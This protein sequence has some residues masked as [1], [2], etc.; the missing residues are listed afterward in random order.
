MQSITLK[1]ILISSLLL[2]ALSLSGW[3][4]FLLSKSQKIIPHTANDDQPDAFMEDVTAI[5]MNKMG[6]PT[7][8]IESPKVIHYQQNDSTELLTPHVIIY[9]DSPEPWHITANHAKTK[10]GANE[11]TFWENVIIHHLAD[12][13]NPVTTMS[14]STLTIFPNQ[15]IAKTADAVIV[16]QPSTTVHGVGLLA[17]WE[18]G[19]VKL[20]SDAREEYVPTS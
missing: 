5:V 20:L 16:N 8:R 19:T 14:T 6:T 13:D 9:R 12:S 15:K 17:N 3:S 11:I 1:N 7:M 2:L 4:A 10:D 18:D